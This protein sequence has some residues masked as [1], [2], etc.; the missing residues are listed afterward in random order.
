MLGTCY[1]PATVKPMT[2]LCMHGTMIM[3]CWRKAGHH[4]QKRN[5]VLQITCLYCRA[6]RYAKTAIS[7]PSVVG[8]AVWPC[9][10][11][12]IGTSANSAAR[13]V[14]SRI[15]CAHPEYIST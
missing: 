4:T 1:D 9:V 7:L 10:R 3:Q 13:R 12:S 15:T 14:T 5:A 8:E 11:A 2:P 6:R